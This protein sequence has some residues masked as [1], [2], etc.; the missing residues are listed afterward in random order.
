MS[1]ENIKVIDFASI[2]KKGKAVFTISDHLMWDD[3]NEHLMILQ[4]KINAYLSFIESGNVYQD[5]P[6]AKGREIIINIVAKYQPNTN[7]RLFLNATKEILQS[8]GYEFK[9]K[10]L[11]DE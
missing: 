9:F 3:K 6:N 5:Y 10:V 2:D 7:A 8:A 11:E 1:V 4:N